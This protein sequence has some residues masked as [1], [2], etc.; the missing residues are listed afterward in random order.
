MVIPLVLVTFVSTFIGG[1]VGLRFKDKLH[2][3]LGFTA[4]VILAV[5]AFDIF[6]EIVRISTESNI[7]FINAMVALV[8]GFLVLHILEKLL[9]IHGE[10][11]ESY[12]HHKHPTVGIASAL[13][14]T[15]HSFL[16]GVGIGLGFQV[17]P[18]LGLIIAVA[19]IAHDFADGL[20]TVSLML[21]S[22]NS[23]RRSFVLLVMDA[24]APIFGGLSTLFFTLPSGFVILYLGFFAGTLLYICSAEILPE[25]HSEHPSLKSILMT[26]LGVM[27][28]FLVTRVV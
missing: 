13:A 18:S 19:V 5:I 7:P 26:V 2:T 20:N 15:A 27:F 6:P 24:V 11:E 12:G 1:L 28:I 17:S 8:M 25:A 10:Q 23:Q 14:L 3:I 22:D 4:G 16:D 9:L 21:M